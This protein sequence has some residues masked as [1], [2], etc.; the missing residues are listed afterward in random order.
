MRARSPLV[1]VLISKVV[2]FHLLPPSQSIPSAKAACHPSAIA[3][4]YNCTMRRFASIVAL[5][6]LLSTAA[7]VL[8]CMTGSTMS[9]EERA[10]CRAMHGNCGEMATMGCCRTEVR[11]DEHPQIA[12]AAPSIELH[13]I[14]I[15]W[16]IP[17][18]VAVKTVPSSF[19]DIPAEHSP[20]GL[21]TAK[22]I[23]LR[24]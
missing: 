7:P 17:E 8:A 9:H 15:G 4:A 10:C 21:L 3:T 20:P 5:L 1:F 16:V 11:T 13:W 24:I 23:V 12:T 6:L 2:V 18:F 22:T 19:F 14:V